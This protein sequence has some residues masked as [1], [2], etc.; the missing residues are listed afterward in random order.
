MPTASRRSSA[1][2]RSGSRPERRSASP[3]PRRRPRRQRIRSDCRIPGCRTV[4][5]V[6]RARVLPSTRRGTAGMSVWFMSRP[7]C[8]LC[9]FRRRT[10]PGSCAACADRKGAARM[11]RLWPGVSTH[12]SSLAVRARPAARLG[13]VFGGGMQEQVDMRIVHGHLVVLVVTGERSA[14]GG[15]R[16]P[17]GRLHRHVALRGMAGERA[18][19]QPA[20]ATASHRTAR[21][22][23]AETGY[24]CRQP[25]IRRTPALPARLPTARCPSW[26]DCW[27]WRRPRAGVALHP[28]RRPVAGIL[29][30][31]RTRSR[32][33]PGEPSP[34]RVRDAGWAL[35]S[36]STSVRIL[37][38]RLHQ[39]RRLRNR[40]EPLPCGV[41]HRHHQSI[42]EWYRLPLPGRI[43]TPPDVR[44]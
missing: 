41:R 27:P 28:F 37:A 18:A 6:S 17:G 24:R 35:S 11:G 16:M 9:R 19:H 36:H 22:R 40:V 1:R 5:P 7:L 25:R 30:S 13:A 3:A 23:S 21:C 44:P 43:E 42:A 15:Q 34:S 2:S 20:Q 39:S 14:A 38:R 29:R 12:T 32:C 4:P 10:T 8:R 26:T 33:R 31:S